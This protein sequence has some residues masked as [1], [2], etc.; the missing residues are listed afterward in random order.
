M[1]FTINNLAFDSLGISGIRRTRNAFGPDKVTFN[2]A[3]DV[4]EANIFAYGAEIVIK[5]GA[6][7]WFRGRVN[8]IPSLGAPDAERRTYDVVGPWWYLENIVF[9]QQWST[10]DDEG[11]EVKKYKSRAILGQNATF[12]HYGEAM[13]VGEVIAE[14]LGW[15]IGCGAAL[16]IGTLDDGP[17]FPF[18]EVNDLTCAECI[19]R[20]ARWAPDMVGWFDY[21]YNPPRFNCRQR[22][23]RQAA[24]VTACQSVSLTPRPDLQVPAVLLKYEQVNTVEGNAVQQLYE[25]KFPVG[26]T[27]REI[28]ALIATLQL[29][30]GS[31]AH[32][33]QHIATA[34]IPATLASSPNDAACLAW[35]KAKHPELA[36]PTIS[37]LSI[38]SVEGYNPDLPRELIEGTIQDWMD[39]ESAQI[40]IKAKATWKVREI[41]GGAVRDTIA[42]RTISVALVATD[43]DRD[44]YSYLSE[45]TYPENP[46]AG[47]AEYLY[48]VYQTL[49]CEGALELVGEDALSGLA[50]GNLVNLTFGP[51]A[52]QTAG[53]EI[54][55]IT[56]HL[57]TGRTS[58]QLGPPKRYG[59]ADL[60]ELLRAN[61]AR[62]TANSAETRITGQGGA[63]GVTIEIGSLKP[64]LD[65]SAGGGIRRRFVVSNSD[66]NKVLQ[67]DEADLLENATLM[68]RVVPVA[69]DTAEAQENLWFLASQSGTPIYITVLTS[70]AW[71]G[72]Q[73]KFYGCGLTIQNGLI[74]KIGAESVVFTLETAPCA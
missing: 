74:S 50:V 30:G 69:K 63:G 3:L 72:T 9:Q 57:D 52:W 17:L 4:T 16:A 46:P 54:Q 62:R 64:I 35:W 59:P 15:A 60:I 25:D 58:V 41:V 51:A 45:W 13:T 55:Q 73:I 10:W 71:D 34:G 18:D 65:A 1:S 39:V 20:V 48:N 47:L 44:E 2:A 5:S 14:I 7:F 56:E 66:A 19:S 24:N 37:D 22:A 49:H 31:L 42:D 40:V 8:R 6:D 23:N 29:A 38:S 61:R 11:N 12:L 36:A 70:A 43:A 68:A 27:G 32:V 28:G 53:A 33:K 26:A 21:A 67:L